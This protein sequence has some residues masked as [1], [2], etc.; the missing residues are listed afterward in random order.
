MLI[1]RASPWSRLNECG[2]EIPFDIAE[3]VALID[4]AG[5][6]KAEPI[7]KTIH[8]G[9]ETYRICDEEAEQA[10]WIPTHVAARIVRAM[11]PNAPYISAQLF[12]TAFALTFPDSRPVLRRWGGRRVHGRAGIVGP[13]LMVSDPALIE[14]NREIAYAQSAEGR[15]IA[16]ELAQRGESV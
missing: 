1:G 16:A 13:G 15:R 2:G 14:R 8:D 5:Y 7:Y 3:V 11:N 12:G 4:K 6:R 10:M 9:D